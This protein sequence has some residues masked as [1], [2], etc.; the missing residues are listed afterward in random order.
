MA[1]AAGKPIRY[2][3]S[4]SLSKQ[5]LVRE[6][7][8]REGGTTGLVCVLSCVEPCQ[9]FPIQRNSQTMRIETT[10]SEA[11]DLRVYRASEADPHGEQAW[12]ILR[13]GVGDLPRRAAVPRAAN[14]RYLDGTGRS[15]RGHAVGPNRRRGPSAGA[16][17]GPPLPRITTSGRHGRGPG[18]RSCCGVISRS[19]GFATET[20][21]SGCMP[22]NALTGNAAA[23]RVRFPACCGCIANMV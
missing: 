5:D 2:P 7:L 13:K 22:V 15:R 19:T 23:N 14:A 4:A 1:E 12:R 20:F 11:R 17:S 16:A 10:L 9:S 8:R 6:L 18:G 21:A 3:A